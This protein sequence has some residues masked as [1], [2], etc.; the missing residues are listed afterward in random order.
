MDYIISENEQCPHNF[1][2]PKM[3]SLND[4]KILTLQGFKREKSS[5]SSHLRSWN[6]QMFGLFS[7]I[8]NI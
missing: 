6:Q 8:T 2:E 5:R 3:M 7:Q 1:Q 4:P